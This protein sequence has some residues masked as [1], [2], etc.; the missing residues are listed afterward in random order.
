MTPDVNV[1]VAAYRAD[2]PHHTTARTWLEQALTQAASGATFSVMPM[3][4]ASFL[5]LVTSPKIFQ[6]P[7]PIADAVSFVGVMLAAT[8]VRQTTAGAEWPRMRSLCLERQLSGNDLPD[9]WLTACVMHHGEHLVTFDRDFRK[10]LPR[11]QLT[12]LAVEP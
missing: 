4:T 8:G 10:L 6:Q 3:V 7:T 12:V 9:A 11:G 1:L 5:R 2:H